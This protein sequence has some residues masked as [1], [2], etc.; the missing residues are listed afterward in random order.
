QSTTVYYRL[1]GTAAYSSSYYSSD[2]SLSGGSYNA[3]YDYGSATIPANSTSTTL[4]LTPRGDGLYEADETV[5]L[6]ILDRSP[7]ALS[8]PLEFQYAVGE[9]GSATAA[10]A[11]SDSWSVEV[12]ATDPAG[13][14]TSSG[15]P[16]NPIVFTLTRSGG[17]N[18]SQSTTVYYELLGEAN[19]G[20]DY[21]VSTGTFSAPYGCISIPS[22]AA[23]A[24][25]TLSPID[26]SSIED[27]ESVVLQ[28]LDCVPSAFNYYNSSV[29]YGLGASDAASAFIDDNENR[30]VVEIVA[31]DPLARETSSG[32]PSDVGTFR[33]TRT[34]DASSALNVYY[35]TTGTASNGSDYYSLSGVASIPSGSTYVDVTLTPSNDQLKE[36]TETIVATLY[37]RDDYYYYGSELPYVVGASSSATIYLLDDDLDPTGGPYVVPENGSAPLCAF[38][39][40]ESA[41]W[42]VDWDLDGDGIFGEAGPDASR[43]SETGSSTTYL[44]FG[45]T[46]TVPEQ[47]CSIS[48][49][50]SRGAASW[51]A[52]T[53]A[54]IRNVAPQIELTF[55]FSVAP[56]ATATISGSFADPGSDTWT[57][58][59]LFG[60]EAPGALPVPLVFN[61]K[62]F[63]ASHSY[64][65][66]GW[67]DA[68]VSI[69]DGKETSTLTRRVKVGSPA[70]VEIALE[71]SP[72]ALVPG[73]S[74]ITLKSFEK[75]AFGDY[76]DPRRGETVFR[77]FTIRNLGSETLTFDASS[78]SLPTDAALVGSFPTSLAPDEERVFTVKWTA[79][80][81]LNGTISIPTSDP[82]VPN[83]SFALTGAAAPYT[84]PTLDGTAL[85]YDSGADA[86]DKITFNPI[87]TGTVLGNLARGR[88]DV[89]FDLDADSAPDGVASLYVSGESFEF[90]PR[91]VD[92][93]W[94]RPT[95][96]SANVSVR[97]RLVH[98]DDVGA[99][100][101]TGSWN[102]FAYTL[103][104]EPVGSL[105]VSNLSVSEGLDGGWTRPG[106]VVLNGSVGGS[107]TR[108]IEIVSGANRT[109][110]TISSSS[111][112][113]SLP[114][115]FDYGVSTTI[116]VRAGAYDSTYKT[117]V[118]GSWT[119]L[120]VTPQ[121]PT[122]SSFA[123][124]TSG[125]NG[126]A[127]SGVLAGL[128][129]ACCEVEISC[130]GVVLGSAWTD[131]NGAFTF[132]PKGLSAV[133]GVV[134]GTLTARAVYRPA[135]GSPIFG[136]SATTTMN[137]APAS[138]YAS[139]SVSLLEPGS[140]SSTTSTP[141]F[142]VSGSYASDLSVAF[143][144]RWK[145][146]SSYD[147]S[148][149]SF[150]LGALDAELNVDEEAANLYWAGTFTIDGLYDVTSSSASFNVQTRPLFYD[151]LVGDY[152]G[153]SSWSYFSATFVR[154]TFAA[155]SVASAA[156]ANPTDGLGLASSDATISGTIS[157]TGELGGITVEFYV[158]EA[159][160]GRTTTDSAGTFSYEP[161]GL[162]LGQV[163]V[164]VVASQWNPI[165]RTYQLGTP[166]V[167]SFNHVA[168][169]VSAP[170]WLDLRLADD[171][172]S[173]GDGVTANAAIRGRLGGSDF[174]SVSDLLVEYDV[175]GDGAP[176]GWTRTNASGEFAFTPELTPGSYTV[177]VRA[178]RWDS[179]A[180]TE[181][182]GVWQGVALTLVAAQQPAAPTIREFGPSTFLFDSQ[183][184]KTTYSTGVSGVASSET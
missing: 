94:P 64:A 145:L 10:I 35:T 21:T 36:P 48:A 85:L 69:A 154:P 17:T 20:V 78:I 6:T 176:D 175:D 89:E 46:A 139:S 5:V 71:G 109:T 28:L 158:D 120:S 66:S 116:Q 171:T 72:T 55:P 25:L 22:N 53:S 23:S 62:T 88:V 97:Y 26:D 110:R 103:V 181:V 155:A 12:S 42:T 38:A 11:D 7:G 52:S 153:A 156:L 61:A 96:G 135:N 106:S 112:S 124:Q 9:A 19:P 60:D 95:S 128:G 100:V 107:G 87:L 1:S 3:A 127:L 82:V 74:S 161:R 34:G 138:I 132:V 163:Q 32:E 119:T 65:S 179:G 57:G 152:V 177:R 141:S 8:P 24:T 170:S 129:R 172:G 86:T 79:R 105:S 108:Q 92:S 39:D 102:A 40:L 41:G 101:S 160:V 81:T 144:Y 126:P 173:Y 137:Y 16:S 91:T 159:C 99:V 75:D 76:V 54:T 142:K 56:G 134:S 111:F 178:A 133:G 118:Y 125:E 13:A 140:N 130:G 43:G 45:T 143:E 180:G 70:A 168:I 131:E 83:F 31:L 182:A 15:T 164:T 30:I 44:A 169:S 183:G 184:N 84:A 29:Q 14:E 33:I 117:D 80:G 47:S 77:R 2:Y 49:R 27:R 51:V 98:Y 113:V 58:T 162:A 167:V 93:S 115:G 18:L 50:V 122:V 67:F 37:A 151:E 146:S 59:I 149:P 147:W 123:F 68:V 166:Q 136:A 174:E 4:T 165:T 121:L 150:V 114:F 157:S 148:T 104:P 90:D 73:L 63:S